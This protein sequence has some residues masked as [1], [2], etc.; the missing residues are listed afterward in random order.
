M[1]YKFNI[2][3]SVIVK[4]MHCTASSEKEKYLGCVGIITK[5]RTHASVFLYSINN[6]H[7]YWFA[8]YELRLSIKEKLELL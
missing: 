2:G 6:I 5:R 7:T 1:K 3:D 8:E 4:K